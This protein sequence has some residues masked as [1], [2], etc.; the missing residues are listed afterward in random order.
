MLKNRPIWHK[1]SRQG[2]PKNIFGKNGYHHRKD[3]EKL[4]NKHV[5][6]IKYMH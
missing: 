6:Y 4:S 3:L 5:Q 2:P 1:K